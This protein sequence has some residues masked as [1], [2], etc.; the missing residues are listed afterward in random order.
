MPQ[1]H[2]QQSPHGQFGQLDRVLGT[3]R[4]AAPGPTMVCIGGVHGNEPAGVVALQRVL[5][6]LASAGGVAVGE[7]VAFAGN[8]EALQEGCR[9]IEQDLNRAWVPERLEEVRGANGTDARFEALEQGELVDE[10]E[11][12][13]SRVRGPAYLLDLHT[14]SGTGG[15]FT[16]VADTLDNRDFA[17]V[18]PG[19]L[20]LGL[21]EQVEGTFLDYGANRGLVTAAYESGQHEEPASVDR[22]EAAVLLLLQAVGMLPEGLHNRASDARRFLEEESKGLPRVLEMRYRHGLESAD[23]FRMKPGYRN[24]QWVE[25]GEVLA[26]D[27][28]GEIRSP[29]RARILMPLY[30]EQGEDGFFVVREFNPAWLALS[31]VMRRMR[32]GRFV[33]WLPGVRRDPNNPA[34]LVVNLHVAR[35]FAIQVFHLL[36][37]RRKRI[38]GDQLRVMAQAPGKEF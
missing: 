25:R 31:R 33:H 37:Y 16:T 4:A 38:A 14:T 2:H 27:S 6:T 21:E 18:I 22:A 19:P 20:I 23:G 26:R 1:A 30:Q 28:D 13:L 32:L 35:L 11:K 34:V 7:F 17:S 10:L 12:A 8:L 29:E 24:F 9:F 3:S 36:G 5:G 15:T